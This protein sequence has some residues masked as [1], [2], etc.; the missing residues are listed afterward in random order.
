M[1]KIGPIGKERK[2]PLSASCY[3]HEVWYGREDKIDIF[4]RTGLFLL[5]R[6]GRKDMCYFF[7][8]TIR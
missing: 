2:D 5:E 3:F 7:R 6:N 8:K 1:D 4:K